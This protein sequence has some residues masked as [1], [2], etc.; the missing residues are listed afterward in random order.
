M[1]DSDRLTCQAVTVMMVMLSPERWKQRSQEPCVCVWGMCVCR[2]PRSPSLKFL[3]KVDTRTVPISSVWFE[4][5][6][7]VS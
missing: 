2:T 4:G 6:H 3:Y 5:H 1:G 7:E